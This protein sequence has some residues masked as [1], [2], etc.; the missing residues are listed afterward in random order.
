MKLADFQKNEFSLSNNVYLFDGYRQNCSLFSR[1]EIEDWIIGSL[2]TVSFGS[3]VHP[4]G[5]NYSNYKV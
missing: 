2:A 3:V 1:K 4:P 5:T